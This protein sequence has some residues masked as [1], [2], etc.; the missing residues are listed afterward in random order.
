MKRKYLISKMEDDI[1]I[2]EAEMDGGPEII[3]DCG[4]SCLDIEFG[5]PTLDEG[6][7]QALLVEGSFDNLKELLMIYWASAALFWVTTQLMA[8]IML[9]TPMITEYF[10]Q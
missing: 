7:E 3:L 2:S 9:Y 6:Q 5:Q 4:D 1:P 10:W 8:Y